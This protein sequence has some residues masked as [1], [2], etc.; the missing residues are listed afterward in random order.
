MRR[1][2]KTIKEDAKYVHEKSNFMT[3]V[4]SGSELDGAKD[5]VSAIKERPKVGKKMMK[6]G[7]AMLLSPDPFGDVPGSILIAS[8]LAMRK[9]RDPA[10]LADIRL[11]LRKVMHDFEQGAL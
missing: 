9:Y 8:G 7:T 3:E 10:S 1:L 2:A 4:K 11:N 6:I 5:A